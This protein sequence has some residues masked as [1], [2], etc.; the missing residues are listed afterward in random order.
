MKQL[1]EL[2]PSA[3]GVLEV[4]MILQNGE[5]SARDDFA[6]ICHPNPTQGGTMTN[7]VVSTLFRYCR[8]VGMDVFRFN[9]RGVGRSTGSVGTGE[10]E[11]IDALT[12]L[13]YALRQTKA[14]RLWLSVFS[15][16]GYIACQ[17]AHHLTL[18]DQ[19]Q[20]AMYHEVHLRNLALIAPSVMRT[21][22]RDLT[23]HSDHA[24]MIYGNQDELIPPAA[25]AQFAIDRQLPTTV[26]DT[27][28]FFHT[29]LVELRQALEY[30]TLL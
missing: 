12:V 21:G 2:I 24:F 19:L 27:G 28:H 26:L 16:G 4:E 14:R 29:K 6:I 9:F 1:I 15:F 11:L 8:D 23:W 13:S 17:V 5:R 18:S 10:N 25:L 3:A 22:M 30:H 7:K 20:D